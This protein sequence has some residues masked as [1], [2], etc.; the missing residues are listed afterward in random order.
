M[1]QSYLV[2][3]WD[4][5]GNVVRQTWAATDAQ[6]PALDL[7]YWYDANANLLARQ[8]HVT[9][10]MS[11]I[12]HPSG[13]GDENAYD[14]LNQM[15]AFARGTVSGTTSSG[16]P[17]SVGGDQQAWG[18]SSEGKPQRNGL[19]GDVDLR[20]T[21]QEN[22][23]ELQIKAFMDE[24][25]LVP[26]PGDVADALSVV[27][28]GWGNLTRLQ[29]FHGMD[30]GPMAGGWAVSK[31]NE[32]VFAYDALNRRSGETY[33]GAGTTLYLDLAGNVI[34][35]RKWGQ[36]TTQNVWSP[37]TGEL[38]L[39]DRDSDDNPATQASHVPSGIDERLWAL[40]D[41]QGNV[42]A[43]TSDTGAV[44][45]RYFY[46]PEGRMLIT[47]AAGQ[48]LTSTLYEW[49]YTFQG[50]RQDGSGIYR[51]GNAEWDY[52]SGGALKSSPDA[53]WSQQ[54]EIKPP[55]LNAYDQVVL[56]VAAPAAGIAGFFVGGP[57]GAFLAYAG[58]AGA[59]S[60]T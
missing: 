13:G 16:R 44:V 9:A 59:R 14:K 45:E 43:I 19:P 12:Y 32:R 25:Y 22:S 51:I 28:D 27:F 58:V 30:F 7:Q 47:N 31:E 49:R 24:R 23:I 1:S 8:D 60:V 15:K 52:L 5:F 11:E 48:T 41:G 34:E 37:A 36:N 17:N 46:T 3:G 26:P 33:F 53:Y 50:G 38:I 42:S 2:D 4:A 39:R 20:V 56:A 10:G 54:L 35:E 40:Y 55:S 21:F 6:N 29:E 57:P 18:T